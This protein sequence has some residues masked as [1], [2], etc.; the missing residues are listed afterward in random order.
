MEKVSETV[1]EK[2]FSSTVSDTFSS[3]QKFCVFVKK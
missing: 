1:L 3:Q 2:N